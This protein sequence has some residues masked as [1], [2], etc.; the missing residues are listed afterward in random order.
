MNEIADRFAN[1]W[2]K[3]REDAGKSQEFMAKALGVS[4]KTIQNWESGITCPSQ[5]VGF[6]WFSVLGLQPLPYYL[7]VLY[8]ECFSNTTPNRKEA[9]VKIICDMPNDIIDKLYYIMCGSHGS[10]V[11]GVIEMINAH[12]QSP[13]RDRLNVA[14]SIETNYELAEA[15][16]KVRCPKDVQPNMDILATAIEMGKT[17]VKNGK[18]IIQLSKKEFKNE[19]SIIYKIYNI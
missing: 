8:P 4:K 13:L 17:A 3:S 5:K 11:V 14:I 9:L 18:K 10:S 15:A 2:I 1:M 12:L 19:S 7:E 6:E 16:H